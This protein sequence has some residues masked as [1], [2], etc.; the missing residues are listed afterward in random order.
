MKILCVEDGS[1][2]ID[3]LEN[4]GLHDGKVLV[5]RQGSTPPFVLD[6]PDDKTNMY[7]KFIEIWENLKSTVKYYKSSS[8]YVMDILDTMERLEETWKVD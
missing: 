7:Q 4:D 5:Y 6:L 8:Q 1:V 2:D 3:S